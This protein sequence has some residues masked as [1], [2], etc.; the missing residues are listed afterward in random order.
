MSVHCIGDSHVRIFEYIN[1]QTLFKDT[2]KV[3]SVTG[4]T[5]LG[6]SN[7]NSKSK[8]RR[9]F[10]A[11][12]NEVKDGDT[13]VTMIGEGDCGYL[14]W[15]KSERDKTTVD[16]QFNLSLF[17]YQQMVLRFAKSKKLAN[18]IVFDTPYPSLKTGERGGEVANIRFEIGKKFTQEQRTELTKKYNDEMKKF[19]DR[20]GYTHL[21]YRDEI[22]DPETGLLKESFR[23]KEKPYDHHYHDQPF[24][25]LLSEKLKSIGII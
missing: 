15:S 16:E 6:L 20:F 1:E 23:N 2:F 7:F 12:E 14:I 8:A 11:Y 9:I 18:V 4:A 10:D 24:S 17:N 25:I 5:S 19:C 3:K 22:L 21:S 13:I